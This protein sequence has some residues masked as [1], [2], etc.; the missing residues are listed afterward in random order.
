MGPRFRG[1][2][3]YHEQNQKHSVIPAKAGIHTITRNAPL[4]ASA[5]AAP[6]AAARVGGSAELGQFAMPASNCDSLFASSKYCFIA[7]SAKCC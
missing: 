5:A 7:V 2:D 4:V 6:Q 1:G 3:G